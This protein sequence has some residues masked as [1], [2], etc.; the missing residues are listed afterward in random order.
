MLHYEAYIFIDAYHS[1]SW[2]KIEKKI[3]SIFTKKYF[4]VFSFDDTEEKV[5]VRFQGEMAQDGIFETT[6]CKYLDPENEWSMNPSM[7]FLCVAHPARGIMESLQ[8][9][10]CLKIILKG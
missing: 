10:K 6:L 4:H 8:D 1:Q 3:R 2:G 7:R 9:E 5:V